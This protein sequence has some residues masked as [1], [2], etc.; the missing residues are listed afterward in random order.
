MVIAEKCSPR[1]MPAETTFGDQLSTRGGQPGFGLAR[2]LHGRFGI[3][4][5]C[6]QFELFDLIVLHRRQ[7]DIGIS[8]RQEIALDA[9]PQR[10]E[11]M[12][13]PRD[14]EQFV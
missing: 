5:M 6:E 11:Q 8:F 3:G 1:A 2:M 13:L 7:G 12:R 4:A 9:L 10:V 14:G